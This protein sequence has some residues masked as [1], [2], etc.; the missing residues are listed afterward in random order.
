MAVV[1]VFISDPWAVSQQFFRCCAYFENIFLRQIIPQFCYDQNFKTI[2]WNFH[3]S[4]IMCMLKQACFIEFWA[5]GENILDTGCRT[6][7]I[8]RIAYYTNNIPHLLSWNWYILKQWIHG[9]SIMFQCWTTPLGDM[10]PGSA[11]IKSDQLDPWIKD[12]L[13]N[14]L[15]STILPLLL[16]NVVSCGRACPSHMTQNLVTVGAKL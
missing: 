13:G 6:P 11:F 14:A 7:R 12:Q 5:P 10:K 4:S 3:I 1:T 2:S 15:L 16:R 8:K 9:C